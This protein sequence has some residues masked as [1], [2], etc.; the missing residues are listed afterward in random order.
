[1]YYSQR[2]FTCWQYKDLFGKNELKKIGFS[3]TVYEFRKHF[4]LLK[5]KAIIAEEKCN[6][7]QIDSCRRNR[8]NWKEIKYR[9]NI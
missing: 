3:R 5:L 9:L 7:S 4:V 2:Y 8:P 1:M 6:V